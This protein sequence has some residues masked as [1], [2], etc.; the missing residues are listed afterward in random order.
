[1]S[2]ST[3]D[4]LR[5]RLSRIAPAG[6][7]V[8]VD[9]PT[10]PRAAELMERAMQTTTDAEPDVDLPR[11]RPGRGPAWWAARV[12]A[13]AAV[14]T[15][16]FVFGGGR[17]PVPNG[18]PGGS[19]GGNGATTLALSM[20]TTP[21][22][23]CRAFDVAVLRTMQVAFE[24]TVTA[25]GN[26]QTTLTVDHWFAGGDAERVTIDVP[27]GRTSESLGIEFRTGARYLVAATGGTV[28]GC[29]YSGPA[30]SDLESAFAEAFGR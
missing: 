20:P 13:V 10:S 28:N 27:D 15:A 26:Q 4:E 30:T 23:R 16:V 11:S 29:G 18:P 7:D 19:P 25:T 9:P 3:D 21:Q 17:S 24:G 1:M 6:P 14:A 12:A 2:E 22:A 5:T 8:P